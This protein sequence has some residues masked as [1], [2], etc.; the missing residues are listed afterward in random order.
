MA[1]WAKQVGAFLRVI[2]ARESLPHA[3]IA[4]APEERR[5]ALGLLL[6]PDALPEDPPRPAPERG[7]WL[8]WLFAPERLDG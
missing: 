1:R 6:A 7:R 8:A 3:P 5:G 4:R 2:F